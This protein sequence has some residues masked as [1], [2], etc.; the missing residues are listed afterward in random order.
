M[1]MPMLTLSL[2]IKQICLHREVRAST[3]KEPKL[4]FKQ[5]QPWH[6]KKLRTRNGA[7]RVRGLPL[8]EHRRSSS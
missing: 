3:L 5:P 1:L 2:Q 8:G 4:Y 7:T 6:P